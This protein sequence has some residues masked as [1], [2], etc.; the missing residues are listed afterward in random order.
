MQQ[1]PRGRTWVGDTCRYIEILWDTNTTGR[2][3][4]C[5]KP[6]VWTVEQ[7]V[8]GVLY[9]SSLLRSPKLPKRKGISSRFPVSPWVPKCSNLHAVE[10]G[11]EVLV[12]HRKLIDCK[13]YR[14]DGCILQDFSKIFSIKV[15]LNFEMGPWAW[16]SA[17]L[18]P[19]VPNNR[20]GFSYS[21]FARPVGPLMQ[22]PPRGGTWVGNTTGR[23][24]RC[25]KPTVWTVEQSVSGVLYISSLL[26]SPKLPKRKGISVRG[27]RVDSPLARGSQS[28]ATS[29]RWDLDTTGRVSR[30]LKPTVWTVEQSV[31]GVL[32]IS[33]LL[34]SPKLPK[35]KGISVRV[36]R[37]DSPLARGSQSAA[38]STRWDLDTTGRVSRCLKPTVWTVEQSVSG[39]L[40]I[41]SL[42]RSPK[43]PKRKGISVR[44]FRVDSPL[45]RGSPD[46][47]TSTWW[48]LEKRSL[49]AFS[50]PNSRE[51][52]NRKILEELQ[53]KKQ[54]LLKQGVAPTLNTSLAVT[55]TGSASTVPTTQSTDGVAMSAS[56]RAALH[57]A[58]AASTGDRPEIIVGST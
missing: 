26:R 43:L 23:V 5:L 34:R 25:L 12:I 7:S 27:F 9:I 52:Q 53:L 51:L 41:S 18:L 2:V 39:V 24:S 21:G 57:N 45:A 35:R 55:S 1:P 36:F 33:S 58:H 28:A 48:D 47:A 13:Y 15:Q 49:M 19:S 38:T 10:P 16:A 56:Q 30:C 3:S 20:A 6:T 44:V 29:T 22:L 46:A 37:V 50:Q 31:S 8:S 32:Y 17:G 40:Y 11:S 14:A 4:R 54:M 42:L